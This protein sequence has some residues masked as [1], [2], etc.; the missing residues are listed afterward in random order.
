MRTPDVPAASSLLLLGF[1]FPVVASA[2]TTFSPQY[3]AFG[4]SPI[5]S[6]PP[7]TQIL[8]A[9]LNG[10]GVPD[11][12][13]TQGETVLLSS[14]SGKYTVHHFSS[15]ALSGGA[16]PLVAGDFNGDGKNDVLFYTFTGGNQLFTVA[17][18]DGAGNFP[19]T[20]AAPNLPGFVTGEM[21]YVLAQATDVNGDGRPD[22]IL[23]DLTGTDPGNDLSVNVRLYL[24]NGNG[25]T[26]KGNIYSYALPAGS[27]GGVPWDDT[28]ALDLLLGDF[29]SDGHAD[30]ALRYLY[31]QQ[32]GSLPEDSNLIILYG[33]GAGQFTAK[34]AYTHQP[35]E[36]VFGAAD[37]NED[38]RTDL[39]GTNVDQTVHV[40]LST[41]GRTFSQSVI[42]TPTLA[43]TYYNYPPIL[44][45]F[46]G[47][48]RKDI[49]FVGA[50]SDYTQYGFSALYQ[51]AANK[52]TP[53]SF[54][55]VDTFDDYFGMMPFV[56]YGPGNYNHDEK[57]DVAFF[58]D[59]SAAQQHPNSAD[60][61]LN[62]GG[63]AIGSCAAPAI[64]IHVCSPGT[65]SASPVKFS[66]SATSFYPIRK[67]E[68]WVDG[69]KKSETYHVFGNQGFSDVG[70]S[71]P[72]GT[73]K[74]SFFSVGFDASVVKKSITLKV[75]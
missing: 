44:A 29:D 74:V 12:I 3:S 43:Q 62:A 15:S 33:N 19:T 40:F 73:H 23:A 60:V 57:A 66:F 67:L 27:Q 55:P 8:Q 16:V 45:D 4:E 39:V 61:L 24:N 69:V 72:A 6:E 47:N 51:T 28:P 7:P 11:F 52:W 2:Q 20:K 22:L 38:G 25:F 35:T 10:D 17:Y 26:D 54:T 70:L 32:S 37:M 34:P 75:P 49:G 71:V 18:G 59:D 13:A 56:A 64:G 30:V 46:D 63:K 1:I 68:V 31:Q 53:G 58:T 14:S 21:G 42:A 41:A 48:G 5:F 50:S 65:S 36:L 9:D